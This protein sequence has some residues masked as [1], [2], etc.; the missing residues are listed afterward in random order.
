MTVTTIVRARRS[1]R[2]SSAA[3]DEVQAAS[4]H[5]LRRPVGSG[6]QRW[7]HT[8][9]VALVTGDAI[10]GMAVLGLV[11]ASGQF[12]WAVA[13]LPLA[14][15]AV[16]ALTGVYRP[17]VLSAGSHDLR[18]VLLAGVVL[19]AAI[20]VLE[21][22]GVTLQRTSVIAA[23]LA[24]TGLASLVRF[25]TRIMINARRKAG[26]CTQRI[27]VVGEAGPVT[28]MV[29]RLHRAARA[30][31]PV[32]VVVPAHEAEL[33]QSLGLPVCALSESDPETA[34]AAAEEHLADAVLLVPGS[35]ID[36][37]VWRGI[38]R[39]CEWHGLQIMF[40]PGVVDVATSAPFVSVAGVPV[41][42][43]P[44]PGPGG[45]G[46]FAKQ[47]VDRAGAGIGL[48]VVW[49]VLAAIALAIRLDSR[50]PV[51]FRQV[52][53]GQNGVP[54]K[55]TKFRTMHIDAEATLAQLRHLNESEGP[56]FKLRD[57][58]RITRVGKMLRK[59]S[60]DELPQLA[61]VEAGAMSLVGPRPPLP[62]EVEEYTRVERRRLLVKP[63]LT[64]LWQ[65]G[66]R[67]GLGWA[68]A[69]QLDIRYVESW[70]LPLDLRILARTIPAVLRGTG[71]F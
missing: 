62:S 10:A 11:L 30:I 47:L 61:N 48:L 19:L 60:L 1:L 49:P 46:Q 39:A 43:V 40:S 71:A 63:G 33:V 26:G 6:P 15:V 52:R 17:H 12:S 57:D 58:P 70:S 59:F 35:G 20:S 27:L 65:V 69:V 8:Y 36:T 56:L 13:G 45:A 50:G 31:E 22:A 23:I 34:V 66:G 53:V 14:W 3:T 38:S 32:A 68:E 51:L 28:E 37:G 4:G 41:L 9:R 25:G 55:I 5:T 29:E 67:S 18:A 64:G 21:V 54:F 7:I 42:A 16:G 44:R 2:T 24:T